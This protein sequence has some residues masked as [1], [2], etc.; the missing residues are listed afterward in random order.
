M[1]GLLRIYLNRCLNSSVLKASA[2][3]GVALSLAGCTALNSSSQAVSLPKQSPAA[4]AVKD[5]L[6]IGFCEIISNSDRYRDRPIRTQV[7]VINAF[8]NQFVYDRSC[9]GKDT[10]AWL[11][12]YSGE[13]YSVLNDKLRAA[14]RPGEPIRVNVTAVGRF[15]GPSKEGFGH[16]N[17]FKFRFIV[18]DIEN[19]EAVPAEIPFPW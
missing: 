8:E 17:A 5:N 14:R 9:Y 10:L 13:V 15:E 4:S 6:P 3:M 18:M 1:L 11:E 16:L 19:T 7:T 2:L 12:F